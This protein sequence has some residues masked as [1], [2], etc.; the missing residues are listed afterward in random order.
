MSEKFSILYVDDEESN[1]RIFKNT[2]RREY[3]VY[4]A[5][6]AKEGIEIL[7]K[8][9]IDIILSDQRMP[10]MTGVE[11]LKY[12]LEK[13]PQL[14]R[15]L[16]TGFTD[17]S[18]LESAINDA[19]IFQYIQKPWREKDLRTIIED[20][21]KIYKLE[22]ENKKLTEDLKE[23]NEELVLTNVELKLTNEK[24]QI[25][26]NKAEESD[27]LKSV[28]F[29]N[30]SHEIRTPM[31]GILGFARILNQ[32]DLSDEQRTKY[33]D[34][35]ISSSEQL[36]RIIEDIVE[37]SRLAAAKVDVSYDV[38]EIDSLF[39]ALNNS[40]RSNKKVSLSF[41]NELGIGD[42]KIISD[43]LKINKI[44]NH[45]ID[46][47]L[48]Y[49]HEGFVKVNCKK[50]NDF[51]EFRVE[52]S[53]IG[54]KP[55]MLT[56]IF[57]YFRQ[58]EETN[59][60]QFGGLGLGLSIVGENVKLLNGAITVES[61]KGKGSTFTVIIPYETE[62][63]SDNIVKKE[64]DNESLIPFK[65]IYNVLIVEDEPINSFFLETLLLRMEP[66][67]E[68]NYAE[69]GQ[70]AVDI[71]QENEELDMVFM[72]VKMPIMNGV[73]ATK[74]IKKIR[75]NLPIIA[76]TA[77]SSDEDKKVAKEAGFDGFISKPIDVSELDRI[78]TKYLH[79]NANDRK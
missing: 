49:T 57:D 43:R 25:A 56:V 4:T 33:R 14:N 11:F 3:N 29:A 18:A 74:Q 69:N 61:E 53:G 42:N 8:D 26:K 46:N 64:T 39:Y 15:I 62:R 7:S 12:S 40:F 59:T 72:D 23:K 36:M 30:I 41:V 75:S 38:F 73:E 32:Q 76:Q 66:D 24:L 13:H 70:Q 79:K 20:A 27:R 1:L 71:C 63:S 10:E 35:I 16:I 52:D 19:K 28:F 45:L 58:E 78:L 55:E 2:F 37:I 48:K 31:N 9:H 22:C 17:F 34:I 44:L 5:I 77:Y 21:L 65:D 68:I 47:A 51:I 54:I 67:F 6:S 50:I 60:R